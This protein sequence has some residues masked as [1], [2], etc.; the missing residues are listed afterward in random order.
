MLLRNVIK[1]AL[2]TALDIEEWESWSDSAFAF[3]GIPKHE[4]ISQVIIY[5]DYK[6]ICIYLK[7]RIYSGILQNL[8]NFSPYLVYP[9]D[10]QVTD[11]SCKIK[12]EPKLLITMHWY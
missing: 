5:H 2:E 8:Q 6:R 10:E 12:G 11:I 1:Y 3:N 4:E 7:R 9:A